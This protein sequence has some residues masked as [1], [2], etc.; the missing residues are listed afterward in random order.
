MKKV[1]VL[2]S[3]PNA[4]GLTASAKDRFIK[5]LADAGETYAKV[6]ETGINMYY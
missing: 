1:A 4:D 5:G 3:S 2:W 6:L